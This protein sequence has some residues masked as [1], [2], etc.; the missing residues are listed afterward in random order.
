M[1]PFKQKKDNENDNPFRGVIEPIN[2]PF[3]LQNMNSRFNP[4][5]LLTVKSPRTEEQ[6]RRHS[7]LYTLSPIDNYQGN[8]SNSP[9]TITPKL[10]SPSEIYNKKSILNKQL[11][12]S[13][14]STTPN[15]LLF[16]SSISNIQSSP[17]IFETDKKNAFKSWE[18]YVE[19]KDYKK[20]D[21]PKY[22]LDEYYIDNYSNSDSNSDSDNSDLPDFD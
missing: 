8:V 20:I 19:N 18:E 2:T 22:N 15:K 21:S 6:K 16:L 14:V 17:S 10:M 12:E 1:N 5:P 4:S 9:Q 13:P 3:S 7:S 11:T